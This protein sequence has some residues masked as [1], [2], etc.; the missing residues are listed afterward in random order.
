MD[1]CQARSSTKEQ[2]AHDD[3]CADLTLRQWRAA[4]RRMKAMAHDDKNISED[5]SGMEPKNISS[6]SNPLLSFYYFIK[7]LL[8]RSLVLNVRRTYLQH[9]KAG[10]SDRWP[11]LEG[12]EVPPKRWSGWPFGRKFALVLTHDVEGVRGLRKIGK[13]IEI[14]KKL[15]FRSSFNFCAK[16]YATPNELRSDLV[17]GGFEVGLH[18]L[19]HKGNLF[20]SK[21]VFLKK[22]P[23]INSYLRE[24]QSVGFR[25]P[26]MY[27]DLKLL[28]YLAI[29]YDSSTFDTDPFEPQPDGVGTIFPFWVKE[30][31]GGNG[32]IELPYTLPQDSTLFLL[33]EEKGIDIWKRKLDWIADK[34]GM[35]L[36]ITHPDYMCL[37]KRKP[38][39]QEY[40]ISHYVE[41]LSYIKDQY[42]GHY[43]HA[44]PREVARFWSGRDFAKED[45]PNRVW[46]A[47]GVRTNGKRICMLTYSYYEFDNRVIRY[48]EALSKR[49][50]RVDVVC[51][52]TEEQ[53]IRTSSGDINIYHIQ[54]RK[55]DEK[56]RMS[57]LIKIML[58]LIRSSLFIAKLHV[59]HPYDLIHVHSVPDFEVFAAL[60]PKLNGAKIILD[61]HDIVPEF[62]ASK[63]GASEGSF[64][65]RSLLFLEKLSAGFADHVIIS[66]HI[67]FDKILNRS[68]ARKKCS[69]FLNYPDLN[70]F[71]RQPS[72][73]KDGKFIVIYPGTLNWHQGIDIAVRAFARIKS[74]MPNAE[75]HIYGSASGVDINKLKKLIHELGSE[76]SVFLK[77]AV[78]IHDIVALMAK[79][80][81]GVVPKRNDSFGGEAFSTK[82]LEFMSL[83]IPVIVSKTKID[84]YYFNESVVK[85]FEP[86]DVDDLARAMLAMFKD[87][88]LRDTFATNALA[89]VEDYSWDH[90]KYEYFELVDSLIGS[91]SKRGP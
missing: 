34:G 89:F 67:W 32:Y 64:L 84:S 59:K 13:L 58:F 80:D 52:R 70:I 2:V 24:W 53:A 43:W 6:K 76:D 35:A 30:N 11:V 60:V 37:D 21:K 91:G 72:R 85:F 1:N 83:G 82:I 71:G 14:E 48:T 55:K 62:Y 50:D 73:A 63:F 88:H 56:G 49:G 40:P 3:I 74:E 86:E 10:A 27:H 31:S 41:F 29:D 17:K 18:G 51:L 22:V 69:V 39:R 36:I 28:H 9:Q 68:I 47:I 16:E 81:L 4:Q 75:F 23:E 78:P 33:M 20:I 46:P 90:K 66:N 38:N 77:G 15:G 19:R 25:H 12:S 65:F 45:H 57:Y 7:P 8:P 44:L 79:A 26:S 54:K 5:P 87:N 42:E 61:I